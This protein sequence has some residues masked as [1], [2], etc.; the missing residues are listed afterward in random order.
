MFLLLLRKNDICE[1]KKKKIYDTFCDFFQKKLFFFWKKK[2]ISLKIKKTWNI[3]F[4]YLIKII[5]CKFENNC[6]KA[7]GGDKL[8]MK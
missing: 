6:L 3:T 8:L 5:M 4:Y 2:A 7:V 1:L